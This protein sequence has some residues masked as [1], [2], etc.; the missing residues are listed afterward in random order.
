MNHEVNWKDLEG[1]THDLF[2]LT[3]ALYVHPESPASL[4]SCVEA[5]RGV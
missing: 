2:C 4:G 3:H 5:P 1:L